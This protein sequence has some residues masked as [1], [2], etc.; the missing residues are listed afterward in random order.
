MDSSV[1]TFLAVLAALV[2]FGVV[3]LAYQASQE[4]ST[5]ECFARAIQMDDGVASEQIDGCL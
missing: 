3:V 5:E 1:K 4:P 2:V